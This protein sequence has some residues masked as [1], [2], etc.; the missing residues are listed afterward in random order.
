MTD[1]PILFSAPMVRALLAGNK[2]QTRRMLTRSR[3]EVSAPWALL[4]WQSDEAWV[5]PG[6]GG[7]AYL[8]V[9]HVDGETQHRVVPRVRIG[10]RL[11]VRETWA[12]L[13]F[14]DYTPTN[15]HISDVRF[16]A[17]DSVAGLPVDV[18]GYPWKPSI[19]MPRWA[20][21]LTLTVTDVR[22]ERLQDISEADAIAE[23][24]CHFV[25]DGDPHK[26]GVA[27]FA[28]AAIV[29]AKYGS[30]VK[31]FSHLWDAV[32]QPKRVSEYTAPGSWVSNP[33]VIATSFSVAQRNIDANS[34]VS[35]EV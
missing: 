12:A 7:G 13:N 10:D 28:R 2:T 6:L 24:V 3:V 19:H 33:W 16:A 20:S 8:K 14:G 29:A 35:E 21:R 18:R 9:P 1:H 5:D 31:A 30:S 25:E 22:I 23:G 4:D 32:Q 26:W 15:N 17:T 34:R 11:W 27:S